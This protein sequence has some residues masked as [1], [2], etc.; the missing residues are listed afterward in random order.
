MYPIGFKPITF[1]QNF[2]SSKKNNA[3]QNITKNVP[4]IKLSPEQLQNLSN[5]SF[6]AARK[7]KSVFYSSENSGNTFFHNCTY[8]E[9]K[10]KKHR[11]TP[12][13][14]KNALLRQNNYGMTPLHTISNRD[15]LDTF[16]EILGPAKSR[17]TL[18]RAME[19]QDKNKRKSAL[20]YASG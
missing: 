17:E 15:V 3:T 2:S 8:R 4:M 16:I 12:S 18:E 7:N 1:N 10:R 5:I 11:I 13:I 19:I 20:L 9:L 14:L 6:G